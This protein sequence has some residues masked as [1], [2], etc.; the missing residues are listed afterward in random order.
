M[1]TSTQWAWLATYVPVS[2]YT[3]W[4]RTFPVGW[5]TTAHATLPLT[6]QLFRKLTARC[7]ADSLLSPSLLYGRKDVPIILRFRE[8][9]HVTQYFELTVTQCNVR[10]TGLDIYKLGLYNLATRDSARAMVV[11]SA[12]VVFCVFVCCDL[13][14][15]GVCGPSLWLHVLKG[16][17]FS[18]AFTLL[19]HSRCCGGYEKPSGVKHVKRQMPA[20]SSHRNRRQNASRLHRQ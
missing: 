15:V 20:V 13:R 11:V 10:R 16:I 14:R 12:I 19:Q 5:W 6:V 17:F 18:V 4:R 7:S 1:V 9:I 2:I 3:L 8:T